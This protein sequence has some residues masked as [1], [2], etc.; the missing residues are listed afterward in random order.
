MKFAAALVVAFLLLSVGV[1]AQ[2]AA[3]C[4]VPEIPTPPGTKLV[5]EI[6]LSDNDVLGM[7]KQSIPAFNQ[8][9]S[10]TSGELGGFLVTLDLNSLSD[11]I[12]DVKQVRAMQF[13]MVQKCDPAGI[14]SFFED[15]LPA[16]EGWSRILY[17]TS[18]IP[19]GAAAVYS[20]VGQDFFVVGV[21]PA[22]SMIY[23][24]RTVGFVDVAKLAA[25]AGKAVK[26]Y[27]EIQ[28]KPTK[29]VAPAK[30]VAP[31]KK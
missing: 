13:K 1:Q 16:S 23:V 19:N 25:W 22:K 26:V 8:A 9:A 28:P 12:R 2:Q 18:A 20:R 30:K 24:V 29:K 7:I 3:P 21:D 4:A 6:N 17:D 31:S 14:V 5:T 15:K 10:G 11:A 27:S